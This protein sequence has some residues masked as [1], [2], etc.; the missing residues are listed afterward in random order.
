MIRGGD[1]LASRMD[2]P[3]FICAVLISLLGMWVPP[4][5]ME[6]RSNAGAP[7]LAGAVLFHFALMQELPATSYLTRADKLMLGVYTSLILG[8]LSTWAMFIVKEENM[9]VVFRIARIVVPL[10]TVVVMGLAVYV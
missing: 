9:G 5:Q 8:M 3:L 7:M 4:N 1:S 6:V 10:L 2:W